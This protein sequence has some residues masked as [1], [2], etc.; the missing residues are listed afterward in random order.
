[1]AVASASSG[2]AA[3]SAGANAAPPGREQVAVGRE[4]HVGLL[5]VQIVDKGP[6]QGGEER[7]RPAA[8]EDGRRY[9]AA[10]GQRDDGLHRYGVEHR[11]G[12]VLA[13]GILRQQ[14]LNI[15]LAE[16]A[17]PR[18]D[19]VYVL[20][21]EGQ[22]VELVRLHA[23][24]DGHLVD[25]GPRTAGAVAVHAHVGGLSVAEEDHLRVLA[26]YVDHRLGPGAG[27]AH[28]VRGGHHLLHEVQAASLGNTHADRAR[29]VQAHGRRARGGRHGREQF[30][31]LFPDSGVVALVVCEDGPALCVQHHGLYRGGPDVETHA[32][33]WLHKCYFSFL[34]AKLSRLRRVG[35]CNFGVI[36]CKIHGFCRKLS[37][38]MLIL[39]ETIR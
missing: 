34:R 6:A 20:R 29:Q 13:A 35:K 24:Q 28:V 11:S 18:S 16:H 27:A 21:P 17:T 38:D 23:Q 22:F 15:R 36:L 12:N 19:G 14:V 8:E 9:V 37:V 4:Q 31:Q 3:P 10:V 33:G 7:E 30:Q 39:C 26:P 32:I 5:Q 25:E 2:S 1:M